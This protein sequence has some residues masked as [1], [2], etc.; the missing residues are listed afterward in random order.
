MHTSN[1]PSFTPPARLG[2]AFAV[3][4]LSLALGWLWQTWAT[5]P[6]LADRHRPAPHAHGMA[7]PFRLPG[8]LLTPGEPEAGCVQRSS[9]IAAP[10]LQPL[11]VALQ[12]YRQ[13]L[14]T[15]SPNHV[16]IGGAELVQG[17][18]T[19]LSSLVA[20]AASSA[21]ARCYTGETS[22][23]ANVC[24]GCGEA[25]GL[26]EQA[27]ARAVAILVV[28]A[29]TGLIDA[30]TSAHTPCF[31]DT[32]TTPCPKLPPNP[33]EDLRNLSLNVTAPPGSLVKPL[34]ASAL[35]QHSRLDTT[36]QQALPGI[37]QTSNSE[38]LIDLV[39]CRSKGFDRNCAQQRLDAI[40]STAKA[41]GWNGGHADVLAGGQVPGLRYATFTGRLMDQP[42]RAQAFS[43]EAMA[44]CAAKPDKHRW[45]QCTG[46][47]LV[48]TLAELWGTG[49]AQVSLAGVAAV[50]LQLAASANGE[51]LASW[52]HV[53]SRVQDASGDWHATGPDRPLAVGLGHATTT[54]Q[55][56]SRGH[57]PQG[58]AHAACLAARQNAVF[59][60]QA[61]HI[62]C[63]D[64][65]TLRP[66][67]AA[68]IA[69]KTGTPKFPDTLP[70]GQYAM[71]CEVTRTHLAE[72]PPGTLA[73]HRLKNSVDDCR[74]QPWKWYAYALK[75]PGSS[76]WDKV[77][78]VLAQ[79]NVDRST[80]FIDSRKDRGSNVAAEVGLT[81]A[82]H[83][84]GA[85]P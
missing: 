24:P 77:V 74:L 63:G 29:H 76:T 73:F 67:T 34:I 33:L 2:L 12:P 45:R 18:H 38:A 15:A 44:R 21:L 10:G 14:R 27:R 3:L 42:V 19:T 70:V 60:D 66:N 53:V 71:L 6:T 28:D 81:L 84:W 83:L 78:V 72:T 1:N 23:C 26:F 9:S 85:Q 37:L 48:N 62:P 64:V 52:P 58:T 13:A 22:A 61:W 49:D 68:V 47:A 17:R 55:Y 16:R 7:D 50:W 8:C 40:Q 11:L 54:L 41:M 75:K 80:G 25:S 57:T 35:L 79:R 69:G 4:S 5:H 39:L 32:A 36:E 59:H 65:P 20:Q 43:T 30:A 82:N 51:A 31:A 46:A 56:L